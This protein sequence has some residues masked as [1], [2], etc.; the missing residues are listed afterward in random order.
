MQ[1]ERAL[2]LAPHFPPAFLG[3]GPIRTLEALVPSRPDGIHVDVLTADR[4]LYQRRPLNVPLNEWVEKA[5]GRVRYAT[6]TLANLARVL[7]STRVDRPDLVYL[8]SFFHPLFAIAPW[9]M[10][11]CGLWGRATILLAPR[12]E[13]GQDAYR[14]K[15]PKK[16]VVVALHKVLRMHRRVIWHASTPDE[17]ADIRRI[18]GPEV[19]IVVRRDDTDLPTTAVVPSERQPG[20]L[21]V[22]FLARIAPI[23]GLDVLLQALQRVSVPIVLDVYGP[24]EDPK[25]AARCRSLARSLPDCVSVTF[26]GAIDNSEVAATIAG[27]D[28]SALPTGGEN[29]G[30]AIAES[31]AAACPV[32]LPDTTSWTEVLR[33]GGGVVVEDREPATWARQ[34]EA[35]ANEGP[36]AW[37]E[38]RRRAARA[39]EAWMAE[40]DEDHLFDI[41]R[42]L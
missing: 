16:R 10:A 27:H 31:L 20:C 22:A 19:R 26:V 39:Y 1:L 25:Y 8:N 30:H 5:Y 4:D 42:A 23:K 40:S 14:R 36:D 41:L 28:L 13:F 34:L 33:N 3:G 7:W 35:Y 9:L 11:C 15:A 29:F 2:V 24:E 21:R 17:A 32:M 38:R 37:R 18:M 12:G 6:P